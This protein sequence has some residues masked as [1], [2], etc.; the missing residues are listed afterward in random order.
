MVM[1]WTLAVSIFSTLPF[2]WRA[3]LI[4]PVEALRYE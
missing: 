3:G 1:A 4:E 2:A